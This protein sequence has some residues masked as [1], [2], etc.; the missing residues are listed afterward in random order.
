[1]HRALPGGPP[2]GEN[3]DRREALL[4][5]LAKAAAR[6]KRRVEA[7]RGDLAR[8]EIATTKAEHARLFVVE[9]ARAPR[10][11]DELVAADWSTG[12]A[13]EVKLALD[14]AR[15]A[16]E[17]LEA[18]FKLAHRLKDGTPMARSRLDEAERLHGKLTELLTELCATLAADPAADLGAM[19][20]R[21][22]QAA[23]RDFKLARQAP[24]GASRPRRDQPRPPYR[25]FLG[26]SGA[27]ILVGRGAAHNDALT[28]H[29][30]RPRDLW[31]HAKGRA[32]AHVVVPLE[33]GR[34]CAP[35]VLVEA[36]HLAVHFSEA[37][38]ERLVEVQYTPRR[39]VRK[40][41]RSAPGLVVLDREKVIVLRREDATLRGLLAREVTE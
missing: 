20:E 1:M 4:G 25:A 11:A 19:E 18:M 13:V 37:R 39:Y 38:E 14:S 26:S 24:P 41:R 16:R 22:R 12:H 29:V 32:G 36:A 6:V 31:L 35:D 21:A 7:V 17:Q 5:A 40:P 15:G 33:K 27:R 9:A 23:P 30:A 3:A 8:A 2:R 10:G 28:L 34:S